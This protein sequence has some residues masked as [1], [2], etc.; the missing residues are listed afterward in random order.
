[1]KIKNKQQIIDKRLRGYSDF[2][3]QPIYLLCTSLFFLAWPMVGQF[4]AF[5]LV[6]ISAF[7]IAAIVAKRQKQDSVASYNYS[8][9]IQDLYHRISIRDIIREHSPIMVNELRQE[10]RSQKEE[11]VQA[12]PKFRATAPAH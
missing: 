1:M 8:M 3:L 7:A 12:E 9:G 4:A 11:T 10:A 2:R 5:L 6:S